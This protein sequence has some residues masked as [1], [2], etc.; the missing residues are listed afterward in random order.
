MP[1]ITKFYGIIIK[2]YF[3]DHGKPHFHALYNEFNGV[4]QIEDLKMIEGDLPNKAK[5]LVTEWGR[6]YKNDLLEMWKTQEMKKLP[7]I[8]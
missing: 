8:E 3:N 6:L 4:F 5:E 2:M 1:V 7:G